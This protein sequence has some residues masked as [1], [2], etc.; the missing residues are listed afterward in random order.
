VAKARRVRAAIERAGWRLIRTNGSHHIYRRG[1]RT[2]PFAY[3]D[4]ADLGGP[5][6]A[7]VARAFDL[8]LAELR[9]LL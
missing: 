6:M 8:T 4:S 1:S 9:R 7:V 3:H 5:A 2:V